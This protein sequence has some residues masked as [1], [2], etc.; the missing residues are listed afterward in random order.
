MSARILIVDDEY[1][2]ADIIAEILM[3]NGYAAEVAINGALGLDAVAQQRPDLAL[4]DNMMPVMDGMTMAEKM[5][6]DPQL[7]AI[8]LV[9]MTAVPEALP[10][11]PKPFDA[12]LR[13]PFSPEELLSVIDRLLPR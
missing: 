6:A 12:L 5:R 4:I 2:L 13:K 3:E 11:N 9:V 1:G 8:P 10:S 7:A